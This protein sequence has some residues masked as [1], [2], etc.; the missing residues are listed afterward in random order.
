MHGNLE[1]STR[2]FPRLPFDF[3]VLLLTA[4]LKVHH[5]DNLLTC[6]AVCRLEFVALVGNSDRSISSGTQYG[7]EI[8]SYCRIYNYN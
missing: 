3:T 8:V 6:T 4:I 5:A 7:P 2:L 1:M